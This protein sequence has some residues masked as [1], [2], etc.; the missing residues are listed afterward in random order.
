M[1]TSPTP[2]ATAARHSEMERLSIASV[3]PADPH[4]R[5]RVIDD[6]FRRNPGYITPDGA[7]QRL[8]SVAERI[9]GLRHLRELF[10]ATDLGY[11]QPIHDQMQWQIDTGR[12]P[13]SEWWSSVNRHLVGDPLIAEHAVRTGQVHTL[14]EPA[15]QAWARYVVASDAVKAAM[16]VAPT[17]DSHG[18][19]PLAISDAWSGAAAV[20]QRDLRKLRA[21]AREAY[22]RA[23][24]ASIDRGR[25]RTMGALLSESPT[26][27]AIDHGWAS[28]VDRY[29]AHNPMA[30]GRYATA[31]QRWLLPKTY[32]ASP[33]TMSWSERAF[34]RVLDLLDPEY[35]RIQGSTPHQ[36]AGE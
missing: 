7:S 31:V 6:F 24:A 33:E 16:G 14:T 1:M 21:A 3:V 9:P 35:E 4:E 12:Q 8:R 28:I 27:A 25:Q 36:S 5:M 19:Q 34:A 22:W 10:G 13:H 17:A 32:P 2:Q 29:S 18:G 11:G 20:S 26:E 15:Q 23:H 30:A